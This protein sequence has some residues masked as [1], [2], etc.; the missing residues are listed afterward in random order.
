MMIL[1]GCAV[2]ETREKGNKE[3]ARSLNCY[4]LINVRS[5]WLFKSSK[6]FLQLESLADIERIF[7]SSFHS[8]LD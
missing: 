7:Y 2:L 6:V 5:A 3:G 8:E 1:S 4:F